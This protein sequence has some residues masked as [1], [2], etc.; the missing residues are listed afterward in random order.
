M[1]LLPGEAIEGAVSDL[2]TFAMTAP[3]VHVEAIKKL[4]RFIRH[5][6]LQSVG[7]QRLSVVGIPDRT[8]NSAENFHK[9]LKMHVKVSHPNLSVYLLKSPTHS[10]R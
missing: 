4:F 9:Q 6:W 10:V 7:A 1:P 2:E 3:P 5:K 8:N